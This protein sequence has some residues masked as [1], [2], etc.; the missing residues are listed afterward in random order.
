MRSPVQLQPQ[1]KMILC[2]DDDKAVLECE[3]DFLESFGYTVLTAPSGGE[4]L[5][6]AYKHSVDVV[7]VDYFM[8]EING[9]EVAIEIRRLK[10]QA[11]I[12]LLSG[13]VDIPEQTL[14]RVDAFVSKKLFG[15]PIV[16]SDCAVGGCIRAIIHSSAA[17]FAPV[18]G[19]NL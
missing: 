7:I 6:L 16:A 17:W 12:I 8:P 2:I 4:G 3:K 11:K 9:H 18:Q 14:N 1:S 10:P 15:E 13:A 5:N 19:D